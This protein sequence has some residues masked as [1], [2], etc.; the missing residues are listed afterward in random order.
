MIVPHCYGR[1]SV[2]E[3]KRAAVAEH[4][5]EAWQK[6][7]EAE[8]P[9]PQQ[10]T[11]SGLTSC[12]HWPCGCEHQI[13]CT[14][15]THWD[16]ALGW[17]THESNPSPNQPY[18]TESKAFLLDAY[19]QGSFIQPAQSALHMKR[20]FHGG[21]GRDYSHRKSRKQIKTR[22]SKRF[23]DLKELAIARK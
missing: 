6:M 5:T 9:Q 3:Q 21:V 7:L 14:A 16:L 19:N 12:E 4:S 23:S 17:A 8:Q 13:H 11:T 2:A 15:N 1:D 10:L 22:N 20:Y 18:S